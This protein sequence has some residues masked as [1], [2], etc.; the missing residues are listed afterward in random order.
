MRC[1]IPATAVLGLLV[2]ALVVTAPAAGAADRTTAAL[3]SGQ[4]LRVGESLISPNGRFHA[5]VRAGGRLVVRTAGGSQ[6]WATRSA[7]SG[8][9]LLFTRAGQLLLGS[10]ADAWRSQTRGSGAGRLTM[11]NN[12]SLAL[13][14]DGLLVWSSRV[15]SRCPAGAGKTVTVDIGDQRAR[16]CRDGQQRRTTPVTTGASA[17]GYGTPTGTWSVYARVRDTTLYPASGGAYPVHFWLPYSG[18]YGFHDSPWQHFAYGSPRYTTQGSHGCVH[19]PARMMAWLF[20]WAAVG[21]RVTI[22]A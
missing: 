16:M 13:T 18:P 14:A 17:L 6:V 15:G 1:V 8:A 2:G 4:R 5:L 22:H 7:G 11:R 12:G 9:S 20:S 3:Q 10:G 21:T 19:V